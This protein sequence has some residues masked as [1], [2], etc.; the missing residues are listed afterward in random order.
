MITIETTAIIDKS[1]QLTLQLPDDIAPGRHR[2]VVVIDEQTYASE[3]VSSED[4]DAAFAEMSN[5]TEYH[6][7]AIQ[8][9]DEFATAQWEAIQIAE[10]N[11]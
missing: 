11:L 3:L 6:A 5:D 10:A 7:E 8:I 2:V 4:I 9:E 1:G